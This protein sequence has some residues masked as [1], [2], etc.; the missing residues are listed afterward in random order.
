LTITAQTLRDIPAEQR[1]EIFSSLSD[2]DKLEL[3][4]HWPF[5]A[6]ENQLPPERWGKAGCYMWIIR[7]GRGW[8]KTRTGAQTFIQKIRE[9]YRY[10]SLCAATAAEVRDIQ[11]KGESGI[12]ACCPPWFM[13]E[14]KP[15]EK[16]LLWPNGA[17]TSFFYGSELELSRGAQSDLIWLDEVH[18]YQ[19]PEATVDNLLLGL[20]LGKNP[21][22]LIT[23]TPKPTRLCR[24]LEQKQNADGSPAAVVTIGTTYDNRRNL[25]PV[26]FD[27]IITKYQ[28]SRLGLQEL[29]AQILDD[30]PNALFRR[31]HLE[32]DSVDG[33]PPPQNICRVIVAV[34]PAVSSNE[35]SNHTGVVVVAQGKAPESIRGGAVQNEGMKHYYVYEDASLI[36]KPDEWGT[37]ARRM[38]EKY[39]AGNVL[40]ETNQG[41]EMVELVLRAAGVKVPF[42]PVRAV[43]DK[44]RRAM[45][46]SLASVQGRIHLVRGP[47]TADNLD[48]L[49]D[50]LVNWIPGEDSPDRLD[51]F[52]HAVNYFEGS[53]TSTAIPPEYQ[54][55]MRQRRL[56]E[57]QRHQW[58]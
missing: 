50:E 14:Y 33:I 47:D 41:G 36:G 56:R 3:Y 52:V 18:K 38:V 20:R 22:A 12:L 27:A 24:E 34:D 37:M 13:P 58:I 28:G 21:L 23:S 29:E 32:R 4:Y 57:R 15:G 2:R 44:E 42:L 9:G 49:M 31:E 8:G 1:R 53:Y 40:Y 16:K 7:A 48:A 5:F 51:A 10:T 39:E 55:Q 35:T 45:P 30:N 11:I 43:A 19:Y 17:V 46:V 54:E 26:F 25:S 6:R